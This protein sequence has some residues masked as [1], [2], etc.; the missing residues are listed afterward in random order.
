MKLICCLA[1]ILSVVI[2]SC[3]TS[4][5]NETEYIKLFGEAQ[6]TTFFISY[7]D[8]L[9]T[10]YSNDIRLILEEFDQQVSTYKPGSVIN[11]F[12]NN[13]EPDNF[14]EDFT[15]YLFQCFEYS[16]SIKE[17]T[18]GYF[19]HSLQN[20][21]NVT[22][23]YSK[24]NQTV[25]KHIRDSILAIPSIF[26]DSNLSTRIKKDIRAQYNFNGIAQGLSVDVLADHLESKGIEN[27][28]V[29]I[30]GEI[31]VKG[32]N[33]KGELWT[34]S[35]EAPNSTRD[36]RK[37]Q[38][39]IAVD[40]KSVVTSGSYRKFKEIDGVKYSH[41]INPKTGL[42]VTHNL[43]SVSVICE[44]AAVADALATA[45]LVMGKEKTIKFLDTNNKYEVSLLFIEA[46]SA[47]EYKSSTYGDFEQYEL[48]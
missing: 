11:K 45:F 15:R 3:N 26:L 7:Y 16:K 13:E 42:G 38:K 43:L 40:N 44:K 36:D 25:P 29:E 41:A 8:S 28:M 5:Q 6:G 48:N 9:R 32:K 10:D 20:L 47:N 1:F 22:K 33:D 17:Y 2:F 4:N 34:V 30:G 12:N 21:M 37:V 14:S 18:D 27:Y 31:R 39:M 24:L 35:L 46:D 23:T 19:D